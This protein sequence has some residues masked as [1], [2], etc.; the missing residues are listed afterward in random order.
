MIVLINNI[1]EWN[2]FLQEVDSYDFYHTYEYHE[3]QKKENEELFM[4]LY[5]QGNVQIGIPFMKRAINDEYS[6]LTSVH[7]YLGPISKNIDANF[8][9]STFVSEFNS[10]LQ[11]EKIVSI[12]SKLNTYI[13]N[14][15]A[16]LNTVGQIESVGELI[17]FDQTI[18]EEEQPGF[19]KKEARRKIRKIRT[20]AEAKIADSEE[21]IDA[22][23]KIYHQ[24]MDRLNAS[25]AFY[26]QKDYFKTLMKSK[27]IDAKIVLVL[28]NDSKKIMAGIFCLGTK[29]IS[30]IELA[31][32]VEEFFKVSPV[33]VLY[34]EARKLFHKGNMK[35]L[36]LGGGKGGR[37]GTLMRFKASYTQK[38]I[39]FNVWKHIV[40]PETYLELQS[41]EQKNTESEFFP[42]YRLAL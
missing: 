20:L 21:E 5:T 42:K 23:I 3:I 38:F 34:D 18:P 1:E 13:P 10:L 33:R 25:K 30:H 31:C 6:D 37:E 27:L 19:Y 2:S 22:F 7:G 9:N 29:E 17:Y 12:F 8:D 26:Y 16:I 36:N 41:E 4:V 39:D 28:E 14:Q 35:Y 40:M 24:N 32:T 11:K 15:N